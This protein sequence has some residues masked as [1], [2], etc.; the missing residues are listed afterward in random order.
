[1]ARFLRPEDEHAISELVNGYIDFMVN[2]K[3]TDYEYY[4]AA[5]QNLVNAYH[6]FEQGSNTAAVIATCA[7]AAD[8]VNKDWGNQIRAIAFVGIRASNY[9]S[10]FSNPA[11][12]AKQNYI[13]NN[14][15][16][17]GMF[18]CPG[19]G[20]QAA[21]WVV[22]LTIDHVV[23][24]VNHWNNTGY[25]CDRVTRVNWYNHVPNHVYLCGPCNSAK[26]GGGQ[27]YK[28]VT[29]PNYSN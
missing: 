9:P 26:N 5:Y 15:N 29:G 23:P 28:I 3:L 4:Y 7:A 24:V 25:N 6:S 27:Y 12:L 2:N 11:L 20:L 8:V 19:H 14:T 18:R 13:N 22:A 21:H 10:A 17:Q 16:L 1:M